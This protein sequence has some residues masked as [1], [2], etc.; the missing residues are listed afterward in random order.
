M[1]LPITTRTVTL[2]APVTV[3]DDPLGTPDSWVVV[4]ANVRAHISGSSGSRTG[5]G[6]EQVDA[7]LYLDAGTPC[8]LYCRVTDH[9]TGNLY[10]VQWVQDVVGVG[11]DHRKA[12][13]RRVRSDV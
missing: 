4:A 2:E 10:A 6:R 12:G 5:S 3:D 8:T 9:A 13:L 11:L 1:T 7:T